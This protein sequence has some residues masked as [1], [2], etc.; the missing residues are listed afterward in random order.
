MINKGWEWDKANEDVWMKPSEESIYLAYLWKA[1]G[2]KKILDIGCGKG[3]HALLFAEF[4]FDVSGIDISESAVNSS[5]ELL[6]EKGFNG[7]IIKADFRKLPFADNSFDAVFS[8]L[9]I[10]HSDTK[11]VKQAIKEIHRVVTAGGEMFISINS[12]DSSTFTSKKYQMIDENT[13]IK[14]IEGPENGEPHFY[15]DSKLMMKL[16]EDFHIISMNHTQ[17]IYHNESKAESFNYFVRAEKK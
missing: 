10:S 3:R 16:L 13:L 17:T 12:S 9:T 7:N 8:F 11:G 6:K 15:A 4:G 1:K 5:S 2:F 14:T